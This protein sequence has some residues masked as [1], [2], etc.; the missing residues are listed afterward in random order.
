MKFSRI[1]SITV[2]CIILGVMLSW[3]YKSIA[4]NQ[5]SMT[6]QNVRYDTLLEDLRKLY[7]TNEALAKRSEELKKEILDLHNATGDMQKM[8]DNFLGQLELANTVAGLND[9]KGSG[10]IINLSNGV[11]DDDLIRVVNSLKASY[12]QA[13][14]INDERIVAMTEINK[15]G[16]YIV[17]NGRQT[18]EPYVIKAIAD[19][20]KIENMVSVLNV[21]V[22]GLTE[23]YGLD[24]TIEKSDDIIINKVADDGSVLKYDLL[25][26]VE[27]D[28][29]R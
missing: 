22:K 21:I 9:V 2:I 27:Q 10:I 16:N 20:G 3:Q 8:E 6:T 28:L 15:A 24:I 23:Q 12:A 4:N 14:S 18:K 11:I 29:K 19:P 25:K 17:I 1:F 7:K 26:P 13:I 5:K